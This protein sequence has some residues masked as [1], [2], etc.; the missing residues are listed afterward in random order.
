MTFTEE[1]DIDCTLAGTD[2][3]EVDEANVQ[4]GFNLEGKGRLYQTMP[5]LLGATE[6]STDDTVSCEC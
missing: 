5:E 3:T 1:D 4:P 2:Y 6:S